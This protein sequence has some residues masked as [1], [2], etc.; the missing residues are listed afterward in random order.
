[1]R[2]K[3]LAAL[4]SLA[5]VFG[6]SLAAAPVASAANCRYINVYETID[7]EGGDQSVRASIYAC[8]YGSYERVESVAF[9][10]NTSFIR[11]LYDSGSGDSNIRQECGNGTDTTIL[12]R[13]AYYN[14]SRYYTTQ[15]YC[16]E[17]VRVT[18]RLTVDTVLYP[19]QNYNEAVTF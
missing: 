5:L 9:Y 16:A 1:M 10:F 4:A 7:T 6:V 12:N 17:P 2:N 15:P 19:D 14:G 13:S 11:K 8:D 3:F 18:L